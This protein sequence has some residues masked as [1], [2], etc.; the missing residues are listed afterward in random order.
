MYIHVVYPNET[1]WGIAGHYGADLNQL[2]ALNALEDPNHLVVGQTILVPDSRWE[3]VV[4]EGDQLWEIADQYGVAMEDL[5]QY[6]HMSDP[7]LLYVGQMLEMPYRPYTVQPGDTLWEIAHRWNASLEDIMQINHLSASSTLQV[8]Q[9]LHIPAQRKPSTEINAYL[10][11]MDASGRDEVLYLGR[12]FTY[13]SPFMY[14]FNEE[15]TLTHLGEEEV[16]EAAQMTETMPLL[17]LTN[18]RR[19]KFD[20]DLAASILRDPVRREKLINQLVEKAEEKGYRGIN[21][22]FEYIYPEDRENYNEFLRTLVDQFHPKNLIVTTALAPKESAEQKGLLYEA[23]DYKTQGDIV[24]FMIIMTYEWG[25][26]GGRP[27]AIA[28]IDKVR[29]VLDYAI[30]EIPSEKIVMGI[31]LYGRDWRIPW[32][33]GTIART[34]SP[35]EAVRLA[36]TYGA[37][38]QFDEKSQSPFF[39]YVDGE[40]QEHEVWFEDARSMQAKYDLIKEYGLRGGSY[41]VLGNPFPQN[42]PVLQNNFSIVKKQ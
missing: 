10:T 24:D 29:D 13:L 36:R 3:Y 4:Q 39:H 37:A 8:G 21:V 27:R 7:S 11:A 30:T 31:P 22:D 32:E 33:E 6:N 19:G 40:G 17:V 42:W 34:I 14:S 18:Y 12:F 9:R 41:W 38:I 25:W 1:L 16:L 35:R 15:G 26:A 28:P 20:S 5:Q 2:L 23:H